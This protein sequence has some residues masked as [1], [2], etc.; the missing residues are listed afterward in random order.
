MLRF[1][2]C[3]ALALVCCAAESAEPFGKQP[4]PTAGCE[5]S[6]TWAVKGAPHKDCRWV[7]WEDVPGSRCKEVSSSAYKA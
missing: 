4:D 7:I 1:M 3:A 2:I 5:D 6:K